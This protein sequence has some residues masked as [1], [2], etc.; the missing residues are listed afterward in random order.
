MFLIS[1][2]LS[3]VLSLIAFVFILGLIIIVHELG[4]FIFAKKANIL[5]HEFSIGM[6]PILY[7]KRHNETLFAIR[8]I[9]IGGF[10]AMAGEEVSNEFAK[11]DSK[12]SLNLK[13]GKVIEMILDEKIPGEISGT[14]VTH[15]LYGKNGEDLFITIALED[16]TENTYPVERNAF[17]VFDA[18]HSQQLAPFDRSFESKT[19]LQRF[20]TIVAG[21]VMNLI[22]A[23]IICLLYFLISGVPNYASNSIG[24]VTEGYAGYNVLEQ[25]DKIISVN[26]TT[27]SSWDEFSIVMD[28]ITADMEDG[29]LSSDILAIKVL[30]DQTEYDFSIPATII[31]NSIGLTNYNYVEKT[32]PYSGVIVGD[33]VTN[34]TEDTKDEAILSNGDILTG[35]LIVPYGT[36]KAD[37][38]WVTVSSWSNVVSVFADTDVADVYFQFYDYDATSD[39]YTFHESEISAETYGDEVLSVQSVEKIGIKLGLSVS[40][41]FSFFGSIKYGAIKFWGDLTYIFKTLKILI[42]PSG[43]RQVGVSDLSGIV[44]IF[45]LIRNYMSSGFLPLFGFIALLSVN[46]GIINLLPIPALDGGRLVFLF[47]ELVTRKKAPKKIEN[48]INNVFFILLMAFMVY[49]TFN[50]IMRFF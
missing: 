19:L 45:S 42:A 10:V 29:T 37:A 13:N 23:A 7:K 41:H 38:T 32:N 39:T 44:G 50:D 43:V 14:V 47:I 4:H 26:G 8:A 17:Y 11:K 5:C 20:L 30:R 2:G 12:I 18:K 1:T 9:P 36:N 15:E 24:E 3:I 48:I 33:V 27:V 31:I 46:I 16:G 25:D 40:T 6:G 49:I 35:V 34:Y 28:G 21:P 22:L